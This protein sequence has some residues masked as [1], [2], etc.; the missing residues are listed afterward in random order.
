MIIINND[1]YSDP[2]DKSND[3]NKIKK[4]ITKIITL[5]PRCAVINKIIIEIIEM[6]I[7][8]IVIIIVIIIIN[9]SSF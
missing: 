7:I 1:D 4:W 9:N 2:Y 6:L 8:T 3:N 5:L